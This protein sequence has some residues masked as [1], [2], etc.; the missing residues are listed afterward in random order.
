MLVIPLLAA[1]CPG[2]CK[3][4]AAVA[5]AVGRTYVFLAVVGGAD[6]LCCAF[7]HHSC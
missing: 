6:C 5:V 3:I 7:A 2:G 4:A 1:D